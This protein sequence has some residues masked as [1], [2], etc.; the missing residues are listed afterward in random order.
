MS[1][2]A[3][4]ER[5]S[6]E[7]AYMCLSACVRVSVCIHMCVCLSTYVC[8]CLSTCVCLCVCVCIN[9]NNTILEK[10]MSI[11]LLSVLENNKIFAKFQSGFRKYHSTETAQGSQ[12]PPNGCW[13]RHG[14]NPGTSG[15]QCSI[16]QSGQQHSFKQYGALGGGYLAQRWSVYMF[17]RF[18]L[19][20]SEYMPQIKN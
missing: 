7:C 3:T 17:E 12:R 14:L 16:W 2:L 19:S 13:W 10:T 8:V 9:I 4:I 1:V 5:Q 18:D 6:C 15:H 11:Q 20:L